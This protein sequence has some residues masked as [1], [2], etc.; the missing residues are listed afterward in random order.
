[1]ADLDRVRAVELQRLD[2]AT[3][4]LMNGV[5]KGNPGHVQAAVKVQERRAKLLGLDAPTKTAT[6]NA[7]I[8]LRALSVDE[9]RQRVKELVAQVEALDPDD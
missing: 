6:V 8:D 9:L 5:S 2:F 3:E 7:N 4:G 1:M